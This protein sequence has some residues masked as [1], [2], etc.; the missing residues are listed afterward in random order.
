MSRESRLPAAMRPAA[1]GEWRIGSSSLG[2]TLRATRRAAAILLVTLV[3]APVQLVCIAIPGRARIHTARLY[4]ATVC[5]LMGIEVRTVGTPPPRAQSHA[6]SHT[7]RGRPV[8]FAA[9]HSSWLDILVLGG[10]I[11]A[12]FVA[13]SEVATWPLIGTVARLGRT[14]FVSRR[15]KDTA[16]ERDAMQARLAAGDNILLFPEGTSNDGSRVGP[17]RSAF[18]SIAE[19]TATAAPLVQPVSVVFDRLAGLPVGRATRTVFAWYGDMS[20]GS[21]FWRLA[22]ERG[23]RATVLLHQPVDPAHFPSRK[24]LAEQV[25]AT[26]ADGAATLRQNRPATPLAPR[27]HTQPAAPTPDPAFA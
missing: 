2:T 14:V 19:P 23:L 11:E 7:Q 27:P 5:R 16:A 21:H 10:Q 12:L 18:F 13:K 22:R 17:F 24:A 25:W 9:N 4:W 26:V 20:L 6:Q 1:P 8:V 15:A 3:A